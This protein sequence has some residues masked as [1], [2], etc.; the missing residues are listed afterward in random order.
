[1]L[2]RLLDVIYAVLYRLSDPNEEYTCC[3]C[4]KETRPRRLYCS[5]ACAEVAEARQL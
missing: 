5:T 1:M 3:E 2:G 4:G